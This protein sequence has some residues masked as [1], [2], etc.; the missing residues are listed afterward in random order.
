LS[1]PLSRPEND[2]ATAASISAREATTRRA[3]DYRR[4]TAKLTETV[5]YVRDAGDRRPTLNLAGGYGCAARKITSAPP[6]GSVMAA[7]PAGKRT[8]CSIHFGCAWRFAVNCNVAPPAAPANTVARL[9][10]GYQVKPK[11]IHNRCNL[12]GVKLKE[13]KCDQRH[14]K[15]CDKELSHGSLYCKL[16]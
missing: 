4:R 2:A 5:Q 3:R 14:K 1:G 8:F 13:N 9:I 15:K 11:Q 16:R 7:M 10:A 12:L 6:N